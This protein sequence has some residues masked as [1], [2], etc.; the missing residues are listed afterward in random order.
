[1]K[2]KNKTSSILTLTKSGLSAF[3]MNLLCVMY[4]F[5]VLSI[6]Q[7]LTKSMVLPSSVN[8]RTLQDPW[9]VLE[10]LLHDEEGNQ[11]PWEYPIKSPKHTHI[12][13]KKK[14]QVEGKNGFISFGL[15]L[16]SLLHNRNFENE[17]D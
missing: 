1:M 17:E 15:K 16:Y 2:S 3:W 5:L 7:G 6:L 12:L 10:I 13:Q 14:N 4:Q 11:F 8:S 9:K